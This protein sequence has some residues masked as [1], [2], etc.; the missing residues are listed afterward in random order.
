MFQ[1]KNN[2]IDGV[3]CSL[4]P[5]LIDTLKLESEK[6]GVQRMVGG[7]IIYIDR[8]VLILKR[9]SSESFL[10]GIFELPSGGIEPGE[11]L[12]PGLL[13]EVLEET[14]LTINHI[15]E[16]S[17]HFDYKTGSGKKARQFNFIIDD[18]SGVVRLNPV[19]HSQY[20][21]IS[22]SDPELRKLNISPETLR[23]IH[24]L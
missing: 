13:R 10:P 1:G 24:K 8:R 4:D 19:E 14:G 20:V 18:V 3:H 2:L 22:P 23:F 16:Y 21:W 5:G 15:S 6:D 12:L 17:G 7:A 9:A 11:R